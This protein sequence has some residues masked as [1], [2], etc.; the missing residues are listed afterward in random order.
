M[1]YGIRGRRD[2]AI[3]GGMIVGIGNYEGET[4]TDLK[5]AYV[6]PAFLDGHIH[7]ESSMVSPSEFERD[8]TAARNLRSDYGSA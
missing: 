4:E 1:F 7:L 6:C 3:E 2:I 8:G 5:G